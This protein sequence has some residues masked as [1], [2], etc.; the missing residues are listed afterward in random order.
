[1]HLEEGE[2]YSYWLS[3]HPQEP[4]THSSRAA[5][6]VAHSSCSPAEIFTLCDQPGENRKFPI[7]KK[8]PKAIQLDSD[9]NSEG[10]PGSISGFR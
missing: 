8:Q 5:R 4:H 9:E 3:G 2:Q 10:T 6:A 7:L 1:M